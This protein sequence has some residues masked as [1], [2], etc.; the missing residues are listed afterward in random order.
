MIARLALLG[1]AALTMGAQSSCSYGDKGGELSIRDGDG[2]ERG[3]GTG[4]NIGP[5]FQTKLS[6]K[7]A[8]GVTTSRFHDGELITFELTVLNRTDAP[9]TLRF[10]SMGGYAD[11]KVFD[12]GTDHQRFDWLANKLFAAVVTDITF[13]AHGSHTFTGTWDWVDTGGTTVPAGEYEAQGFW[14]PIPDP[15][16]PLTT[17]DTQS[18]RVPFRVD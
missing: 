10:P 6:L 7:N 14:I 3:G 13:D 1:V 15:A 11:F 8:S 5:T 12:R 9:I 18:P 17:E 16:R 4:T 2:S